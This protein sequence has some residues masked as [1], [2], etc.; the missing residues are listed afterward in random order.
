MASEPKRFHVINQG[1]FWKV[2]DN[3][4]TIRH[5]HELFHRKRDARRRARWLNAKVNDDQ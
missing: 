3:K 1:A 5:D 2:F 4:K